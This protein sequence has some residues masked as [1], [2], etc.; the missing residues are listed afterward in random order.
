MEYTGMTDWYWFNPATLYWNVCN[1][2]G[3]WAVK[4]VCN[5]GIDLTSLYDFSIIGLNCSFESAQNNETSLNE[6]PN[7]QQI[8]SM[9]SLSKAF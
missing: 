2:P 1:N 9:Y 6:M 8:T 5:M 3:E 7:K 4:Y